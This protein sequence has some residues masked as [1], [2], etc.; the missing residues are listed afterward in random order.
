M[1]NI[2]TI[3][4]KKSDT[5]RYYELS[6][7]W[8]RQLDL[9]KSNDAKEA[10]ETVDKLKWMSVDEWWDLLSKYDYTINSVFFVKIG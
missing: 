6:G 1:P 9:N 4:S 10:Y 7:L 2:N 5:Q 3:E 8:R